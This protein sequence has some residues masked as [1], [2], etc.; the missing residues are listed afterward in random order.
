MWLK[1]KVAER[2]EVPSSICSPLQWRVEIFFQY[3]GYWPGFGFSAEISFIFLKPLHPVYFF[4]K[5]SPSKGSE[6]FFGGGS[7]LVIRANLS[8]VF[9]DGDF[10]L[11][12]GKCWVI[13]R[14]LIIPKRNL[15]KGHPPP[16]S[17]G[18]PENRRQPP[19][20]IRKQAENI[21]RWDNDFFIPEQTKVFKVFE[22]F[23]LWLQENRENGSVCAARAKKKKLV[24]FSLKPIVFFRVFLS[25]FLGGLFFGPI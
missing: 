24:G 14:I 20:I 10:L 11:N 7:W 3:V 15:G 25:Y 22:E 23:F 8:G 5:H 16:H 19:R 6:L 9:G 17:L 12:R 13:R 21:P 2:T 4:L 1:E 18:R